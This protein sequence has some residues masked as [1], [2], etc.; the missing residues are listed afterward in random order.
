MGLCFRTLSYK[1]ILNELLY[2]DTHT[3]IQN[4]GVGKI[5]YG[6]FSFMFTKAIWSKIQQNRHTANYY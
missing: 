5:F 1:D 6:V 3:T 4:F 2:L